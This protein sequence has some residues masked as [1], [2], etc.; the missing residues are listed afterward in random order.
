MGKNIK[1]NDINSIE[2][3][4]ISSL[5]L[6]SLS[7]I[8]KKP[9][10]VK[11]T[12][13]KISS[14]GGLLLLKE[15]ENKIGIIKSL[16]SCI[17]DDRH[18]SYV[19]HSILS[20]LSQR[21]Y[22]IAAGYEDTNDCDTLKDD[23]ILKMCS[24]QLPET[25]RALASQPTM[26]RMENQPSRKELYEMGYEL[27]NNFVKSYSR[28]PSV[29]IL[30]CDDTNINAH[31][32]QQE[33]VFNDYYG[34]YC[35]MPLHIYEG[36]SGKLIATILKPGRRS[37]TASVYGILRRI[38]THIRKSWKN[39]IIL[40]RGDSHFCCKELMDWSY[41]QKNV[42]FVSGI[43]GNSVLNKLAEITIKSAEREYAQ[44]GKAV[45]RYH[46]FEY[47]AGSWTHSQRVIVKVEINS[48][49]KNIRYIATD[50][51]QYRA[52]DIYEKG[53]CKRG[54]ME[55]RIKD[56]KLFLQSDRMS[57]NSFLA[58]QFRLFLHSA[59][60]VL[61]HTL[62]KEVLRGTEYATATMKTIQLKII[63]VAA[64]VNEIKTKIC[65]DLPAM[66]TTK[67]LFEK[68]FGIFETLRC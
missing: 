24:G 5:S 36:L 39:T 26:C 21:I 14:D 58:N 32:N 50:M 45:K 15:V 52:R 59:A 40:V 38:I 18:Q 34:E 68:C 37:K 20:M 31:G 17:K 1:N 61:I 43:T 33:I 27:L 23:A 6:F 3:N 35:F 48:M 55:L 4:N 53:Y 25:G 63:K 12:T 8:N 29:I 66:F 42:H 57:C 64:R 62:Q 46:S 65:I 30:D 28:E 7:P 13:E 41:T 60:Y 54:N 9:V 22:Q 2:K 67:T 47:Q 16:T 56:H 10:D 44:Y 19:Q 49:G 11:F 51:R